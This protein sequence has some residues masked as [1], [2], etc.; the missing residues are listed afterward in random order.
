MTS[1]LG[2]HSKNVEV[3]GKETEGLLQVWH[4]TQEYS[5]NLIQVH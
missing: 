5:D 1:M 2:I 4:P 3:V